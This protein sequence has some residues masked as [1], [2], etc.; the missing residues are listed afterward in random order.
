V[1]AARVTLQQKIDFAPDC[2]LV[3]APTLVVTGEA[4]LDKIVPVEITRRYEQLI[5]GASYARLERT[6]HIGLL[7]HP[8]RFADIV[9]DFLD[10]NHH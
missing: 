9:M 3:Q 10:A 5:P 7:T 8:A 2:A 6:G 4:H 1:M